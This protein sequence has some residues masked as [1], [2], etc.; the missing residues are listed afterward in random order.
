MKHVL[1]I[2]ILL[3]IVVLTSC[4]QKPDRGREVLARVNNT[5]LYADE[6]VGLIPS[7]QNVKDSLDLLNLFIQ[8]WIEQQL[9]LQ[10]ANKILTTSEKNFQKKIREYRNALLVYEWEKKILAKELD[11]VVTAQQI[12]SYYEAN[13]HEF[14][15]QRDIVRVLYIKLNANTTR[16]HEALQLIKSEPFDKRKAEQFC[17]VYAVNYFLDDKSWL[18]V[19][20]IQKEIPLNAQQKQQISTGSTFIELKD[21]EYIYMLKVLEAKLKGSVSPLALE[22]QTIKNIILQKRKTDITDNYISRL[23]IEA[24]KQSNVEIFLSK[25]AN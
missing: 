4:L 3:G 7:G 15:L 16:Y 17:A 12:K 10:D 11:T 14:V 9:I 8:K 13:A 18:Y 21:E 25:P 19:D 23:R 2:G 1:R 22:E 24:E 5:Y 20:D 6:V